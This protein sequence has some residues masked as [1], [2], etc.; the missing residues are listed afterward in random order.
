MNKILGILVLG[1][2]LVFSTTSCQSTKEKIKKIKETEFEKQPLKIEGPDKI[3]IK[4][5]CD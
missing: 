1:M 5:C 4:V 2:I 3:V